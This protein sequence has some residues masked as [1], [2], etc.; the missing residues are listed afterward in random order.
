MRYL[1]AS[2][3][4]LGVG[5][6]QS[7]SAPTSPAAPAS[8]APAEAAAAAAAVPDSTA[9]VLALLRQANLAP[10]WQ[11]SEQA[12]MDG[13]FG[14]DNYRISFHIDSVWRNATQPTVYQFRGRD[15][16][17]KVIT[18]FT[19][20]LSV[21][22]LAPLPDTADLEHRLGRQSY[23]AFASFE[24]RED[25]A[26]KGAGHCTGRA[27][28]D[29]QVD[30]RHQAY[31]AVFDGIDSGWNNPTKGCGQLFR[32]TWQDNRTGRRQPVAW[33][34]SFLVIV[35]DALADMGLG[36]RG[37]EVHPGLARYGW[38]NYWE[39]DEWWAASPKPAT[40]L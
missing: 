15:R 8:P 26:A 29:F 9:T 17:K 14:P 6:C 35:P 21:T 33:A 27:A 31:P 22:R 18:P 36:S 10:V 37:D 4:A 12:A 39:N 3:L 2:L 20:T 16:Y 34:S 32:G 5:A 23:T 30:A 7:R 11:G 40:I 13:F 38:N 1:L 28:L 24:L 19:G 25:P